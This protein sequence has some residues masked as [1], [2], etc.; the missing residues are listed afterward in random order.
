M[1]RITT[2]EDNCGKVFKFYDKFSRVAKITTGNFNEATLA[3]EIYR[4]VDDFIEERERKKREEIERKISEEAMKN[5]MEREKE[6]ELLRKKQEDESA[7]IEQAKVT[8][9]FKS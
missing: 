7:A 9:L 4:C 3:I 2:F 1:N 5:Q 8:K 6:N